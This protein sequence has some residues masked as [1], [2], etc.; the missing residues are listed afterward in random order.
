MCGRRRGSLDKQLRVRGEWCRAGIARTHRAGLHPPPT[1]NTTL[2]FTQMTPLTPRKA[3]STHRASPLTK[4]A[5]LYLAQ[6]CVII[7]THIITTTP[8]LS[9]S[10]P[11]S[12]ASSSP[13]PQ[14]ACNNH[15]HNHHHRHHHHLARER[16]RE[17]ERERERLR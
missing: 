15:H 4:K 6:C 5:S 10:S 7:I 16:E 8:S 13:R 9:S 3:M 17:K 11:S 12:P 14:Q 1:S 2:L